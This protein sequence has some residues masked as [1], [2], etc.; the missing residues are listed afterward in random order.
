ML[1]SGSR[2]PD[3]KIV[4][5]WVWKSEPQSTMAGWEGF[6]DPYISLEDNLSTCDNE[7]AFWSQFYF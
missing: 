2:D 1:Q 7:N 4:L 3:E 5:I 6:V